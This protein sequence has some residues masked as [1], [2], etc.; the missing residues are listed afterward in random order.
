MD[1]INSVMTALFE[2][3]PLTLTALLECIRT[4][5]KFSKPD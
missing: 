4:L 1:E 2:Y 5:Y 3:Y